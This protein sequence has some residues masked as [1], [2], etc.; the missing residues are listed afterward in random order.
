MSL[1]NKTL[2]FGPR[3]TRALCST[4][5]AFVMDRGGTIKSQVSGKTHYL[6][7]GTNADGQPATDGAKYKALVDTNAKKPPGAAPC[8]AVT[9]DQLTE[10]FGTVAL[11]D[12]VD[13][14]AATDATTAT[15]SVFTAIDV[16]HAATASPSPT[17]SPSS[18]PSSSAASVAPAAPAAPVALAPSA[19][20][21]DVL[22]AEQRAIHDAALGGSSLFFTGSAGTGK[23]FLLRHLIGALRA[24][25][26]A[27]AVYV[28]APTGVA[29]CNV[30]GITIHSFA[31]I[32]LGKGSVAALVKKVR[33]VPTKVAAWQ[34]CEVLVVDEVS[35]LD[36]KLLDTVDGVARRI[37]QSSLPFG[38]IQLV[39]CGDFYQ[40]PPVGK[41]ATFAFE[42]KAWAHVTH[43]YE[44]TRVFRQTDPVFVSCLNDLRRGVVTSE[45]TATL[46]ATAAHTLEAD[47]VVPT[48]LYSH[49][50]DVD[51]ENA[52]QLATLLGPTVTYRA[53]DDGTPVGRKALERCSAA[54]VL[55]LRVGAQV[56]LL[57][58][59]DVESGLANGTRGV[60]VG[61]QPSVEANA[62]VQARVKAKGNAPHPVVQFAVNG[63]SRTM[64]V[65]ADTWTVEEGATTLATREQIPLKLAWAISIHKAQGTTI[66]LLEADVSRCFDYGQCYVAL[67]RAVS[68]PN[69]RVCGFDPQSVRAHPKVVAFH[70]ALD[71]SAGGGA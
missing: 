47:G 28:T 14:A 6:L 30:G 33:R 60:V 48:R 25:R 9:F 67:S 54:D 5:T 38:G 41:E 23:S 8:E 34:A 40:L 46:Q 10:R 65:V 26:G 66:S 68:L 42:S 61:F 4:A 13:T 32:G 24:T 49:N 71:R 64:T 7:V 56:M 63:E 52:K 31:G 1:A 57:K 18:S 39:L 36:G 21:S 59:V 53:N 11:L 69:L 62:S 19:P 55:A 35:M 43:Q 15:D 50:V 22:T 70:A 51:R 27:N 2:V 12:T 45:T 37:R 20:V 44:L 29:A 17:S 3:V 16:A 58:N